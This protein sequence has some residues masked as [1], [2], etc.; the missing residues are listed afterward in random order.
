MNARLLPFT[1]ATLAALL[2]AACNTK[3]APG[4]TSSHEGHASAS[5][6]ATP[7]AATRYACPMHPEVTDNKASSCPKCG[8]T[9]VPVGPDGGPI[10]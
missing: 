8:M 5:S 3:T 6:Q 2:G 4:T 10:Q 9:L 7:A 1:V